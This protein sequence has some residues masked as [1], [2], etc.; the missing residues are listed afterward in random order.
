MRADN[1]EEPTLDEKHHI[2]DDLGRINLCSCH[3]DEFEE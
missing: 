3:L 1:I 2:N